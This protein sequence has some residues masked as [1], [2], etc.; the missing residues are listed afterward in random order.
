MRNRAYILWHDELGFCESFLYVTQKRVRD[1]AVRA[2]K[3]SWA[4]MRS[5][6]YSVRP[7]EI[8]PPLKNGW[9]MVGDQLEEWHLKQAHKAVD[10]F[11]KKLCN[12]DK[13]AKKFI[14]KL[15]MHTKS[16]KLKKEYGG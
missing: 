11:T 12:N 16:G 9:P 10:S 6:G 5:S 1:Q 14:R 7:V 15:G 4:D 3:K 13:L 2:F 8:A